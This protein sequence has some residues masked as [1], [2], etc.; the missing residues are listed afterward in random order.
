[1]SDGEPS[2]RWDMLGESPGG[3]VM[4]VIVSLKLTF[5]VPKQ[6]F[7][8]RCVR[9]PSQ[10]RRYPEYFPNIDSHRPKTRGTRRE[11]WEM[12]SVPKFVKTQHIEMLIR[13]HEDI[14]KSHINKA[15][16]YRELLAKIEAES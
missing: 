1:M 7:G 12:P 3:A 10:S 9:I 13:R 4:P 8:Y 6:A 16:F 11:I 14:S 15:S 5:D 2:I